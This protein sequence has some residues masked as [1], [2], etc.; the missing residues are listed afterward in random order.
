MHS[1]LQS[2]LLS[3]YAV[4]IR[5]RVVIDSLLDGGDKLAVVE[6]TAMVANDLH[7]PP[8]TTIHLHCNSQIHTN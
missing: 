4:E 1:Y 3:G 8:V 5:C 7:P 6:D 2:I